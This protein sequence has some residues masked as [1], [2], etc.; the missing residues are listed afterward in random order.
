MDYTL[1]NAYL[2]VTV[3]SDGAQVKSVIRK[4]DSVEHMWNA[5]PEVWG[6]HAPVMFPYTGRLKDGILEIKGKQ[7]TGKCHGF[8]SVYQHSLVY[9]N[10]E[11]L[12]L[13]L[14]E[15]EETLKIWPFRFRLLSA[16]TLEADT[17][18]HTLTVE[19]R[20]EESFTFGI[21]FH[22]GFAIPFD[23]KHT[24]TDYELR[25]SNMES[26]ICLGFSSRGLANG[27]CYYLGKNIQTIAVDDQLFA[28]D[29]HC[30]LNISSKTLGLYEKDSGRAV[31]C[32]IENFPYVLIWSKPGMPKFVCIE[33]WHSLPSSEDGSYAWEDKP[34]AAKL[35]P[36]ESW[37]T[38]METSFV[39]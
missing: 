28:N 3:T 12:V 8:A 33:P 31:V 38:T 5:D 15:N 10:K 17:L 20:D 14:T 16:F 13:Q 4:S 30:M 1:E 27:T 2:K 6:K 21:G 32:K 29:S 23:E 37:S 26:P 22:P 34:A 9:H 35:A 24:A 39:R 11:T 7:Y 25:F 36:G 19:N 18:R